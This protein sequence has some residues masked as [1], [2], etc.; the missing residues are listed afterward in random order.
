M[1]DQVPDEVPDDLPDAE[2]GRRPVELLVRVHAEEGQVRRRR[3][4]AHV[5]GRE[6]R[7]EELRRRKDERLR[8]SVSNEEPDEAAHEVPH[9]VPDDDEVPD[10]VP[11]ELP[12]HL[13]PDEVPDEGDDEEAH[14]AAHCAPDP[15]GRGREMGRMGQVRREAAGHNVRA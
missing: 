12:E 10:E 2:A 1:P 5:L 7:R 4:D 13:V 9:L 6:A 15:E 8:G 14:G 11:D 3:E